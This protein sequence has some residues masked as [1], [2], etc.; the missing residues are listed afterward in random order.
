MISKA[1]LEA[2]EVGILTDEQLSEA[3]NHFKHLEKD[4]SCHGP[5]YRLVWKDVF[6]KLKML[7]GYQKSRN[8]KS[9]S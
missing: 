9:N 3:I 6:F 1:T 4:L 8:E 2:V 5:E 7:E